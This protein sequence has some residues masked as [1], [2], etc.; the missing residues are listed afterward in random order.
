MKNRS[1]MA[2]PQPGELAM[3]AIA[4]QATPRFHADPV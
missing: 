3:D 2:T 4:M 1:L